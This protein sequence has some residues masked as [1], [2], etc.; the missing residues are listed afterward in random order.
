MF[1]GVSAEERFSAADGVGDERGIAILV[2]C[3]DFAGGHFED[4]APGLNV[5]EGTVKMEG[6]SWFQIAEGLHHLDGDLRRDRSI[7]HPRAKK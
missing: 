1:D 2:Y 5:A 4:C 6:V 7:H 3:D